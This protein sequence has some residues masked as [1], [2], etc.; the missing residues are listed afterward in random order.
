MRKLAPTLIAAA[1]AF[2][3][4]PAFAQDDDQIRLGT[5]GTVMVSSGGEYVSAVNGQEVVEGQSFMVHSGAAA[6]L[7]YE[8][9]C[10]ISYTEPGTYTVPDDCDP[11]VAY[12]PAGSSTGV[13]A[14]AG[15]TAAIVGGVVAATAAAIDS[16]LG[17]SDAPPRPPQ[18]SFGW[19][20]SRF[21]P[22]PDSANLDAL[23]IRTLHTGIRPTARRLPT[24]TLA[25]TLTVV[26][27]PIFQHV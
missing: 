9:D 24:P 10:T 25:G 27:P 26:A 17:E 19:T 12:V 22:C 23:I 1:L 20:P 14:S 16:N 11:A 8:D 15:M 5:S 7:T 2:A 13:A 18:A 21:S 6:T 4:A 3:M